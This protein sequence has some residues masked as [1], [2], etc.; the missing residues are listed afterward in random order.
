MDHHKIGSRFHRSEFACKCG[1]GFDTVDVQLMPLLEFVRGH[2]DAPVTI[3]SACRCHAHNLAVGGTP[4]S[5]HLY[6]R[7]AD[8]AVKG[9]TP[10]EVHELLESVMKGFGGLGLYDTFVHVD[11]RTGAPARW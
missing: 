8:I 5:Q 1:C 9:H 3:N 10:K 2:F 6:G 4:N 7:A 11:T